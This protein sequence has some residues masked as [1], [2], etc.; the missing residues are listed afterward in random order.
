MS[1]KRN[2]LHLTRLLLA[3]LLFLIWSLPA[4][5]AIQST[6][7]S[8]FEAQVL[9][10]IRNHPEVLLE[11]VE[12]YQ[13]QKVAIQKEAQQAAL[14]EIRDNP[15]LIIGQSP[16]IGAISQ[17]VVVAEFSDFQCPYCAQV[18]TVLKQFI[19]KHRNR[20][21]L[22]YKHFPLSMIHSEALPAAKAAW[23]A[24]RQDKFWQYHDALF[25]NQDNLSETLYTRVAQDLR[26]NI[27]QFDQDR[28]GESAASAIQQDINL[29]EKLKVDGTPFFVI[30][31]QVVEGIA[32]LEDFES[33]LENLPTVT[34][35]PS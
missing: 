6:A 3:S 2:L 1:E 27:S 15:Q 12:N 33:I 32:R 8:Q 23:A 35:L 24:G 4:H 25:A 18:N 13:K 20:V 31:G 11:S 29:A 22:A 16:V 7:N 5:A 21:T 34:D 30:N 10:I 19:A 28:N 17:K 14:Q 26:L 9:Q